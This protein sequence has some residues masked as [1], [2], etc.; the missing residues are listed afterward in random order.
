MVASLAI[1]SKR[2]ISEP[3]NRSAKLNSLPS[4]VLS[5]GATIGIA[6]DDNVPR[7]HFTRKRTEAAPDQF[8]STLARL[9]K[10]TSQIWLSVI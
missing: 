10:V 1:A 9:R 3:A 8:R 6:L 4:L 2:F 5:P 7:F